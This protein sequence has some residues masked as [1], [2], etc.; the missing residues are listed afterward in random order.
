MNLQKISRGLL[1]SIAQYSLP[2]KL[3]M[4]D[5]GLSLSTEDYRPS[6][7]KWRFLR[8]LKIFDSFENW[9]EAAY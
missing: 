3:Q 9:Q 6:K 2:E 1:P 4:R 5:L 7:K 8:V